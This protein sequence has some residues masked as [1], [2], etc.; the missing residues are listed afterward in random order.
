MRHIYI[1]LGCFDGDT[2]LQFRN[3]KA[4]AY[5]PL[6]QWHTYAFD[7]SPKFKEDWKRHAD[8]HTHFEQKAAW[9]EDGEIEFTDSPEPIKSTIMKE[10][11]NWGE[12]EVYK[13]PCFDFSK[14]L[15]QF[16][17]DHVI[18]KVDCEGAELPILTKMIQDDTDNIADLTM[19]EWHDGK[20]PRYKSNKGWIWENYRGRL[21]EWR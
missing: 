17:N 21:V 13:V 9:I 8:E 14:W 10:K 1:D 2:V 15:E 18:L 5:D 19:V 4:L 7:A 6:I 20:M 16:R 12:G 11:F 3:W